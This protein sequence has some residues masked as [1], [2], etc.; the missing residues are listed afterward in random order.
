MSETI[1]IF[2]IVPIEI[3][4]DSRLTF[5]QM[6]VLIALLSFRNKATNLTC[7]TREQLSQRCGLHISHISNTTTELSDLGWLKKSGKGGFS[8]STRYEICV[9]NTLADLATVNDE[10]TLSDSATVAKSAT[11]ADLATLTLADLATRKEQTNKQTI[12]QT[13][14][15]TAKNPQFFSGINPQVVTDYLAVRKSKKAP[16]V[17]QTVFE[18]L[19]REA[20]KAGYTIEQ[21]LKTCCERNWVGFNAAWVSNDKPQAQKLNKADY[22]KTTTD[23]AYERIFGQRRNDEIEVK[24]ATD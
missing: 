1:N 4:Q 24:H 3:L 13:I 16:P 10:S 2:S 20:D 15:K 17:S 23:L 22:Q 11:V 8:K 5:R 6:R 14:S 21:A 9:P 7:P 18:G 12:K 19:Q